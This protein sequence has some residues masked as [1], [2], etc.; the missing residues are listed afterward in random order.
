[1]GGNSDELP[2]TPQI[3]LIIQSSSKK[4]YITIDNMS[5]DAVIRS[6][7]LAP[8]I[9][10]PMFMLNPTLQRLCISIKC[11]LRLLVPVH[12]F[13]LRTPELLRIFY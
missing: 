12:V 9:P 2:T 6:R 13:G 10:I 7:D 3:S 5:I 1:M 4:W 11:F 8:W